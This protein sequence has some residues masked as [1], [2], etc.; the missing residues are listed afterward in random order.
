MPDKAL[1]FIL[2]SAAMH[3]GGNLILKTSRRKLAFNVFMHGS[4]SGSGGSG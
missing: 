1:L 4:A 2:V 3:A